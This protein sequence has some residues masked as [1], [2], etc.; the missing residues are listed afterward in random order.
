LENK[1]EKNNTN[2]IEKDNTQI[3]MLSDLKM[4]I[5][6]IQNKRNG[7][8]KLPHLTDVVDDSGDKEEFSTDDVNKTIIEGAK[9]K[10][11]D[12]AKKIST[13]YTDNVWN[14][15]SGGWDKLPVYPHGA[16]FGLSYCVFLIVY[17]QLYHLNFK[18]DISAS[19]GGEHIPASV[20]VEDKLP[21]EWNAIRDNIMDSLSKTLG[22]WVYD[23]EYVNIKHNEFLRIMNKIARRDGGLFL[24]YI[25]I[26]A[27]VIVA[28]TQNLIPNLKLIPFIGNKNA[29]PIIFVLLFSFL[30]GSTFVRNID[31]V[32]EMRKKG[33]KGNGKWWSFI[34]DYY[35]IIPVSYF[36]IVGIII[37]S[38]FGLDTG[39]Q[40]SDGTYFS[41]GLFA[42]IAKTLF[43]LFTL[44]MSVVLSG[45]A[46]VPLAIYAMM[47]IIIPEGIGSPFNVFSK[48]SNAI[49]DNYLVP[50]RSVC[51]DDSWVETF[52]W[53]TRKLWNNKILIS[54]FIVLDFVVKLYY[55]GGN[56]RD[57]IDTFNDNKYNW[58]MYLPPFIIIIGM[59][60]QE[61]TR[62]KLLYQYITHFFKYFIR[63]TKVEEQTQPVAK[64]NQ[65]VSEQNQPV[66]IN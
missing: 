49:R 51:A 37:L 6:N 23:P 28:I 63:K 27:Q 57:G 48:W 30:Y 24:R 59:L 20:G 62:D 8:T 44:S 2:R 7:F 64:Q 29:F 33:K 47:W 1:E 5:K 11:I 12:D 66:A 50:E 14:F 4:R 38:A 41:D 25:F 21:N 19:F 58:L 46:A 34:V 10:L 18:E 9:K 31:G 54:T 40:F 56:L 16:A 53:L 45:L 13:T 39:K 52:K 61:T 60:N 42:A 43:K 36:T 22:A 3:K 17:L 26:P 32:S 35:A 65:P 15:I 55:G